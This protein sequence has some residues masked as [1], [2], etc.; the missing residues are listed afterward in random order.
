M[1]REK[2]VIIGLIVIILL[3]SIPII[4]YTLNNKEKN[5]F[6]ID[7]TPTANCENIYEEVITLPGHTIYSYC[8][9]DIKIDDK[10]LEEY[11]NTEKNQG[12]TN[13]TNNMDLIE[14]L[15]DG[16]TKVYENSNVNLKVIVCNTENNDKSIYFGTSKMPT[17]LCN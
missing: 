1:K 8:L 9:D 16:G 6:K 4:I 15:S 10:S 13:I 2:Q 14:T 17:D 5:E 11:L 7:L 12:I 3:I